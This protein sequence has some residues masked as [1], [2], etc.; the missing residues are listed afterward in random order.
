MR[1]FL[2]PPLILFFTAI[3]TIF[4]VSKDFA[5]ANQGRRIKFAFAGIKFENIPPESRERIIGD[6]ISVISSKPQIELLRPD[7]V[8]NL[9]GEGRVNL[10][11]T[12]FK[13][14]SVFA[15]GRSL[16]VDYI[17]FG[18]L[19]NVSK[20]TR[21]IFIA[22]KIYRFDIGSH[23]YYTIDVEQVYS[24]FYEVVNVIEKEFINSVLPEKTTLKILP[25]VIVFSLLLAGVFA[26]I[27]SSGKTSNPEGPGTSEPL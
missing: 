19:S 23:R 27:L 10:I 1:L 13:P 26:L 3:F 24:R 15:A 22:G 9:I 4:I 17:M 7:D 2:K 11:L 5:L 21:H 12:D 20:D 8:K 18:Y 25:V 16:N 14:D 6:I